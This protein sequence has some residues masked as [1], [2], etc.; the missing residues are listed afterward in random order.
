MKKILVAVLLLAL[1]INCF[2]F[3]GC[4]TNKVTFIDSASRTELP[5]A[6]KVEVAERIAD[7]IEELLK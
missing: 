4:D 3:V 7:R 2:A 5:L 6:S 1:C